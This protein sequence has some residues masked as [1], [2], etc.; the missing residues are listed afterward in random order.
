MEISVRGA[1][2]ESVCM[3]VCI[4]VSL[5]LYLCLCLYC[6]VRACGVGISYRKIKAG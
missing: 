6:K 1:E 5:Y 4:Y 2:A 3:Y